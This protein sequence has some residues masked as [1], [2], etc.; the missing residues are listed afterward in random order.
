MSGSVDR[1]QNV[2]HP[3]LIYKQ[4]TGVNHKFSINVRLEIRS[5]I[6]F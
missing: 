2:Y 3:D 4:I 5:F 1:S 6:S